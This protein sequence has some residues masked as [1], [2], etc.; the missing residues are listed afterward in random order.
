MN[1]KLLK[2]TPVEFCEATEACKDGAIFAEKYESMAEVWNKCPRADW[3]LWILNAIKAPTNEKAYR[4]FAV[5]C[6]RNTPLIGGRKTGDLLTDPRSITALEVAERF[7]NGKATDEELKDAWWAAESVARSAAWSAAESAAEAARAAPEAAES[8]AD[9]AARS[10]ARLAAWAGAMGAA[11]K[12]QA[13]QFRRLI[14][15]PFTQ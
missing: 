4:L 11:Q 10:A 6:A 1:K 13:H 3:L 14:K 8:A 12:A 9:L 5:W 2:M 15:N 7:A